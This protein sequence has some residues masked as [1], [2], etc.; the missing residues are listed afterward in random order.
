MGTLLVTTAER[1]REMAS[2][3]EDIHY[4]HTWI[5]APTGSQTGSRPLA[6]CSGSPIPLRSDMVVI[7]VL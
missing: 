5:A 4:V 7:A 3:I 6:A 2:M 1:N